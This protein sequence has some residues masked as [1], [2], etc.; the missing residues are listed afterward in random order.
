AGSYEN[1]ESNVAVMEGF[2]D[3]AKGYDLSLSIYTEGPG[4]VNHENDK[5]LG[6]AMGIGR[7]GVESKVSKGISD[8]INLIKI[9]RDPEEFLI[10]RLTMDVFGFSRGAAGARYCIHSILHCTEFS[11]RERLEWEGFE[12]EL[13]EVSFAGLYDT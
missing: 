12:V 10:K 4:S 11:M 5:L 6:F 9:D 2:V 7:S 3:K 13:D 1:D 8:A